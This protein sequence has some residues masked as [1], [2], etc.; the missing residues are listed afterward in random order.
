MPMKPGSLIEP[1]DLDPYYMVRRRI[2]RE[3]GNAR[4]VVLVG[5]PPTTGAAYTWALVQYHVAGWAC[6]A[7]G[8]HDGS[9]PTI[10]ADEIARRY[11]DG[12]DHLSRE[13]GHYGMTGPESGIIHNRR[14][15]GKPLAYCGMS[16]VNTYVP[17]EHRDGTGR[18]RFV[19][20]CTNCKDTY[21]A[22]N[23]GRCP[24]EV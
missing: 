8:T 24:I 10:T 14:V 16:A 1:S 3:D 4:T 6:L 22:E 12:F 17:A 13:A 21:R 2:E 5:P 15:A 18:H 11:G 23:Y 7:T 19:Q 9:S 20:H